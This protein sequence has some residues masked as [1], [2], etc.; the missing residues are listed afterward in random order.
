MTAPVM[1]LY[2]TILLTMQIDPQRKTDSPHKEFHHRH[3]QQARGVD[4]GAPFCYFPTIVSH[5]YKPVS[6]PFVRRFLQRLV[7]AQNILSVYEARLCG[8]DIML[9]HY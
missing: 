8:Y 2:P 1:N 5:A 4:Y 6:E 3:Q 9:T 7:N